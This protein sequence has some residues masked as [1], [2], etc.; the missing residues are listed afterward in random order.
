MLIDND[1]I[2]QFDEDSPIK[3]GKPTD[4]IDW[5]ILAVSKLSKSEYKL[6]LGCM[7]SERNQYDI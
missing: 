3:N 1:S 7:S 4:G 5:P 2:K 6:E